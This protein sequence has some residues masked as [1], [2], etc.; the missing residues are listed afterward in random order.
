[1]PAQAICEDKALQPRDST[2]DMLLSGMSAYRPAQD[3]RMSASI[4][5]GIRLLAPLATSGRESQSS[6]VFLLTEIGSH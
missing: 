4:M 5:L 6:D 2:E 3:I 1:M